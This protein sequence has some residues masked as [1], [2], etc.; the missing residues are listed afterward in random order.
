MLVAA[1]QEVDA[2][3]V[4]RWLTVAG[5][6]GATMVSLELLAEAPLPAIKAYKV[7]AVFECG[8]VLE[9][10]A[11][12]AVIAALFSR[13]VGSYAIVLAGAERIENEADLD[14][15]ERN[16]W[17][18]LVPGPKEDW[19]HQ[20][21]LEHGVYL[22][23]EAEVA[24]FLTARVRRDMEALRLWLTDRADGS[25]ADELAR[26]QVLHVIDEAE[27]EAQRMA[28][29][30][31]AVDLG[32][33]RQIYRAREAMSDMRDSLRRRLREDARSIERA[34]LAS[35][36]TLQE[37]L[38]EQLPCY[39]NKVEFPRSGMAA[40]QTGLQQILESYITEGA[41]RWGRE[42]NAIVHRQ[43]AD[44]AAETERLLRLIDW[45]LINQVVHHD[46]GP[47]HYPG[48]LL[49]RLR[50]ADTHTRFDVLG[51]GP[52]QAANG[53][54][55]RDALTAST[56]LRATAGGIV[57]PFF[58]SLL[59]VNPM[60]SVAAG[61]AGAAGGIAL[62]RKSR[63]EHNLREAERIA[64]PAIY[65]VIDA[66]RDQVRE[67]VRISLEQPQRY[68]DS[69]LAALEQALSAALSASQPTDAKPS[70]SDVVLERLNELRRAVAA[71]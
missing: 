4:Q 68:L 10:E 9:P 64:R 25:R 66:T 29:G 33:H 21:L 40:T 2:V 39:L 52:G 32:E 65:Q 48:A 22:W 44:T 58:T 46:G 55:F 24:A 47:G 7:V 27:R 13:P 53:G 5:A 23:S 70:E 8:R 67:Q 54:Q 45:D 17:R 12:A 34:L 38:L 16:T 60:L 30:T 3:G 69:E 18:L 59:G 6:I 43:E 19:Y 1:P 26:A 37:D 56:L 14:F 28:T 61:I 20:S 15:V 71:A 31:P 62:D 42:A 57:A 50:H 49:A 36:D 63:L 35:L 11:L 51:S 41:R